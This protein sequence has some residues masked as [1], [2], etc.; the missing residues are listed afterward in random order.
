VHPLVNKTLTVSRCTVY[1][2]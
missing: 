2:W 1:M